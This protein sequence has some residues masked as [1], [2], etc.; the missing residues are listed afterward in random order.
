MEEINLL[1]VLEY[2]KNKLIWIIASIILV[3]L[4]GNIYTTITRV[5]MYRSNTTILLVG[6]NEKVN[7][8]DVSLNNNLVTTYSEII[9]SRKVLTK[10]INNLKL[11]YSV[12]ELSNHITVGTKTDTQI[13]TVTVSDKDPKKSKDIA[14]EV[15]EV[16]AK[17]IKAIYRLDNVAIIDYA[18]LAEKPYNITY[19]KDNVI[20]FAIGLVLSCAVIFTMFYF[21]TTIKSTESIEEKLG[22]NVLG[23][24]PEERRKKHE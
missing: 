5:P 13:I 12:E 14:D 20:Y 16:F 2:F 4:I 1:E 19:L 21:D 22:L 9:K 10:V 18:V 24:V 17:E 15:S 6:S 8:N 11:E 3:I 7:Q 23:V